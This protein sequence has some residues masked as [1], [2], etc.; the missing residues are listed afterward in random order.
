MYTFQ[1]ITQDFLLAAT[2]VSWIT[3]KI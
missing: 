2:Y 1:Q 3:Y